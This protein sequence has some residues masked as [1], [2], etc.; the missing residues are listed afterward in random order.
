MP[1]P[2]KWVTGA[3]TPVHLYF[4]CSASGPQVK[5]SSQGLNGLVNGGNGHP[6]L[7]LVGFYQ[8]RAHPCG[9]FNLNFQLAVGLLTEPESIIRADQITA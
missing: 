2:D 3:M 9:R 4:W 6:R 7:A 5:Q 1:I 8:E